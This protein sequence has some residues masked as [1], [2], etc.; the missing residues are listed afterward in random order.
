MKKHLKVYSDHNPNFSSTSLEIY[1]IKD[2]I[3]NNGLWYSEIKIDD[4]TS[5]RLKL[6]QLGYT[7]YP[8]S[9]QEIDSREYTLFKVAA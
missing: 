6:E 4:Y 7:A 9:Y 5:D 2:G 8:M 1:N 3:K